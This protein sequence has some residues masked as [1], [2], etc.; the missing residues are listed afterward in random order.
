[1]AQ[2]DT[3]INIRFFYY[4]DDLRRPLITLCRLVV[5]GHT[6]YGWAICGPRDRPQKKDTIFYDPYRMIRKEIGRI[7]GGRS[8]ALARAKRALRSGRPCY[9]RSRGDLWNVRRYAR[10]VVRDEACEVIQACAAQGFV[11]LVQHDSVDGLP[12]SMQPP[13]VEKNDAHTD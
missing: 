8:I 9:S 4:R 12:A 6:T 1:M 5:D 2:A 13:M 7:P 11:E 10:P 3:L